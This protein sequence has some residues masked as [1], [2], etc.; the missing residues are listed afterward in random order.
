MKKWFFFWPKFQKK[1]AVVQ[2]VILSFGEN[3]TQSIVWREPKISS[4]WAFGSIPWAMCL[5]NLL[6]LN[7]GAKILREESPPP[8]CYMSFVMCNTSCVMC[9]MSCVLC[10]MPQV[11]V[12][13]RSL[14]KPNKQTL[15]ILVWKLLGTIK[16]PVQ[17]VLRTKSADFS[18]PR[19]SDISKFVKYIKVWASTRKWVP[20]PWRK[21]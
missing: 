9:N 13:L 8:T 16:R 18:F 17:W 10:P 21:W 1:G 5:V 20:F 6:S 7:Q 2:L 14:C 11:T 3:A 12:K 4:I 15:R 19:V